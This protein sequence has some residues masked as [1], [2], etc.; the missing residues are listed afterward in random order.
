MP[1]W[2]NMFH[3]SKSIWIGCITILSGVLKKE[4]PWEEMGLY[5]C[6]NSTSSTLNILSVCKSSKTPQQMES[7]E[8]FLK[9]APQMRVI[10]QYKIM[11][12]EQIWGPAC[13]SYSVLL[14]HSSLGVVGEEFWVSVKRMSHETRAGWQRAHRFHGWVGLG[15]GGW[16]LAARPMWRCGQLKAPV[17][18]LLADRCTAGLRGGLFWPQH[19]HQEESLLLRIDYKLKGVWKSRHLLTFATDWFFSLSF[20]LVSKLINDWW[21]N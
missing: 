14:E 21:W 4:S 12:E 18:F 13:P 6:R 11:P 15:G 19:T 20:Q 8:V 3:V 9:E 7:W 1:P 2:G 5:E 16:P 10:M 17:N